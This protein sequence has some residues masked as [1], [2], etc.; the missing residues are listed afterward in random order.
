MKGNLNLI[1]RLKT[2]V[3]DVLVACNLLPHTKEALAFWKA[4]C[5]ADPA[6]DALLQFCRYLPE[7]FL[8]FYEAYEK[9]ALEKVK[10]AV[11]DTPLAPNEPI[12]VCH[13]R[14]DLARVK[15]QLSY[16]R[17]CGVRHFVYIDNKSADGTYEYLCEQRDVTLYRAISIFFAPVSAA[18]NRQVMDELGYGKWYLLVDSDE[19]FSYPGIEEHT[20]PEYIDRL[21]QNNI[22]CV[23]SP[24]INMY[25]KGTVY[26]GTDDEV[27][28]RF[29]WFETNAYALVKSKERINLFSENRVGVKNVW[30]GKYSLVKMR[31]DMLWMSCTTHCVYPVSYN[32]QTGV[33]AVL[34]HYKF[35]PSDRERHL[36]INYPDSRK[37]YKQYKRY[38][39]EH[40]NESICPANAAEFKTSR[41][42]FAIDVFDRKFYDSFWR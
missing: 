17:E 42:L 40:P 24:M 26:S 27:Y 30:L 33:V 18:W 11:L 2:H 37:R 35:I 38:I 6:R 1:R 13:T 21:E 14:D 22:A 5:Q 25:Q 19:F 29:V 39:D 10:D 3:K 9:R 20:L 34:K 15:L 7:K 12:L 31:P 23:F 41:D 28:E 32:F 16:Y 4:H 8:M 36:R